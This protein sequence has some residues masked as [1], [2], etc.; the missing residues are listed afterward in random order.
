MEVEKETMGPGH[1]EQEGASPV[2][3]GEQAQRADSGDAIDFLE[4]VAVVRRNMKFI[5]KIF[6]VASVLTA[7]ISLFMTDIYRSEAA[8]YPLEAQSWG[9]ALLTTQSSS[10]L[11][12]SSFLPGALKFTPWDKIK[13][14]LLSRSVTEAVIERLGLMKVFFTCT[15]V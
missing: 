12:L 6:V 8:L 13:S 14:F 10:P 11:S 2:E 1:K 15:L 7:I 3:S 4:Y 5:L 9:S